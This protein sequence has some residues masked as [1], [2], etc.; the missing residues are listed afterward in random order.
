MRRSDTASRAVW[1]VLNGPLNFATRLALCAISGVALGVAFPK[2]DINLL[3]WVAFVPLLHAI[4]GESM[5]R[6]FGYAARW[7]VNQAIEIGTRLERFHLFWL[8]A[9]DIAVGLNGI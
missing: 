6:V 7:S 5:G 1:D 8:E 4:E 3:A 9:S 2:F